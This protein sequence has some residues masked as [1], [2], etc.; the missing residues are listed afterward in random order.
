M[1]SLSALQSELYLVVLLKCGEY[2]FLPE[3]LEEL[4][5]EKT[6]SILRIFAGVT[7]TIPSVKELNK[8]ATEVDIYIRIN[9]VPK[10]QRASVVNTLQTEY[11]LQEFS[12]W[13]IYRRIA[14]LVSRN[15]S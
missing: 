6:E 13:R 9:R 1:D 8:A 2:S 5:A 3:L 12:V 4:G 11:S 10:K 15:F 7:F 14:A